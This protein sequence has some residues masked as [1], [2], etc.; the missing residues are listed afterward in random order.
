MRNLWRITFLIFFSINACHWLGNKCDNNDEYIT[1]EQTSF[2]KISSVQTQNSDWTEDIAFNNWLEKKKTFLHISPNPTSSS[3]TINFAYQWKNGTCSCNNP[4]CPN[5]WNWFPQDFT[6]EL[7]HLS[8][9][10]TEIIY[11]N[12]FGTEVIAEEFLQKDGTYTIVARVDPKWCKAKMYETPFITT[13]L[14]QKK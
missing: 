7:Y 10:I 4:N 12:S 1:D 14:V 6:I 3:V 11:E 8:N 9:K 13:F 2:R 5:K